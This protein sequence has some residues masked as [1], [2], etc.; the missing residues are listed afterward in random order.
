MGREIR[1]VPADWEHPKYDPRECRLEW[2]KNAYHPMFDQDYDSAC[3]KWYDEVKKFVPNEDA[4]WYHDWNGNPPDKSFYRT[5]KWTDEEATH[6]QVY[7][8]VSEGTPVTPHFATKEELIEYLVT[9]GD[10]W[11]QKRGEDG[12]HRDSAEA[13]VK[14]EYAPSLIVIVSDGKVDIQEPR[15]MK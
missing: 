15:A 2:Q 1:K 14:S 12:W 8:T 10:T 7:E 5:R 4:K 11:N 6:Y 9:N 13:F 3:Q